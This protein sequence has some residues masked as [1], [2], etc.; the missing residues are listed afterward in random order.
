MSSLLPLY[1]VGCS[2]WGIDGGDLDTA[3]IINRLHFPPDSGALTFLKKLHIGIGRYN[4][5]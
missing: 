4:V 3:T 1:A 2:V 5:G